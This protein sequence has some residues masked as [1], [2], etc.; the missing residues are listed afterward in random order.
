MDN[1]GKATLTGAHGHILEI[2]YTPHAVRKHPDNQIRG[3]EHE[4]G[5]EVMKPPSRGKHV[6]L[7]EGRAYS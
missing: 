7:N 1:G 2:L 4:L 5:M 3:L 6:G